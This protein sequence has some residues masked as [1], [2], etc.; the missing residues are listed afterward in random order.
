MTP[1][2]CV[3]QP[4]NMTIMCQDQTVTISCLCPWY[5][6]TLVNIRWRWTRWTLENWNTC[7]ESLFII[8]SKAI[9]N[10]VWKMKKCDNHM[11]GPD[12]LNYLFHPCYPFS[13]IIYNNQIF[14]GSSC[15]WTSCSRPA[16]QPISAFSFEYFG[17][18]QQASYTL[19]SDTGFVE[20]IIVHLR[21]QSFSQR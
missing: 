12:F 11:P 3:K 2:Y 13:I 17:C 16:P 19:D 10:F 21:N 9:W 8:I 20:I 14:Y 5:Y 18:K 4:N 7:V 15:S 1:K 6:L